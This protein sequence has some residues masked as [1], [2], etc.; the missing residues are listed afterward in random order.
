M[1]HRLEGHAS[2]LWITCVDVTMFR[3]RSSRPAWRSFFLRGRFPGRCGRMRCLLSTPR[4]RRM[5]SCLVTFTCRWF[6]TTGFTSVVYLTSLSGRTTCR[7]CAH[8]CRCQWPCRQLGWCR[9]TLPV[10]G[11]CVRVILRKLYLDQ[12][13]LRDVL[14]GGDDQCVWRSQLL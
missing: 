13:G 7:S 8:C 10:P 3:G 14:I 12:L 1:V 2:R 9:Q 6:T 11:R 4:S 5:C